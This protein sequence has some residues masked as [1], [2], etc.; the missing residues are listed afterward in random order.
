MIQQ[1]KQ[2]NIQKNKQ[3]ELTEIV[4][5]DVY[6]TTREKK[7]KLRHGETIRYEF[8]QATTELNLC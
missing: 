4:S 7:W 2:A 1:P 5:S 3:T 8:Q 6:T